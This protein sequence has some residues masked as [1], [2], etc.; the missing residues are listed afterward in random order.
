[1]KSRHES[2]DLRFHTV[3][4][5]LGVV[6]FLI[7][8]WRQRDENW[9]KAKIFKIDVVGCVRE[10]PQRGPHGFRREIDTS[11]NIALETKLTTSC[12]LRNDSVC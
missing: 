4:R 2:S 5:V 6:I 7:Q 10:L 9:A 8:L 11:F 12:R 3:T 1:M